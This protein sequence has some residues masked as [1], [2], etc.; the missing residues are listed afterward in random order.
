[1]QHC[2]S[3]ASREHHDDLGFSLYMLFPHDRS[4]SGERMFQD[5]VAVQQPEEPSAQREVMRFEGTEIMDLAGMKLT[6]IK[7]RYGAIFAERLKENER[8]SPI[9][10]TVGMSPS[11][12][13]SAIGRVREL[14]SALY[15]KLID[16]CKRPGGRVAFGQI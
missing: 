11:Q 16:A 10:K 15:F 12:V 8:P 3:R 7:P 2:F 14:A 6:K 1:M 13:Y 4:R 9:A 5:E